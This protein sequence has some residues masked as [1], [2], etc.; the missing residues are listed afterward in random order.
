MATG[1]S[2]YY[3][4]AQCPAHLFPAQFWVI[5]AIAQLFI[6]AITSANRPKKIMGITTRHLLEINHQ[7]V[8]VFA[9]L[10]RI[11]K[12]GI[13]MS[14]PALALCTLNNSCWSASGKNLKSMLRDLSP[15]PRAQLF[16]PPHL[17]Q[18]QRAPN[19][20]TGAFCIAPP[21]DT[22]LLSCQLGAS[23]ASMALAA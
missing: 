7:A 18:F 2:V 17:Q 5:A 10:Q 8:A 1:V 19:A 13:K 23:A 14:C 11:A 22:T 6:K 21:L 3:Q 12:G 4:P 16:S 9:Q 20:S 15:A